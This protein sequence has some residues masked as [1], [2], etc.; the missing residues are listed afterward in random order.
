MLFFVNIALFAISEMLRCTLCP[1]I[2]AKSVTGAGP[3]C[4]FAT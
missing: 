4:L 2:I 3:C 1:I